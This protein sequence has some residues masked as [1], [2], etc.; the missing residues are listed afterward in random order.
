M[1]KT[2]KGEEERKQKLPKYCLQQRMSVANQG[3]EDRISP[4]ESEQRGE[5]V[6]RG[7]RRQEGKK[8]RSLGV[9]K[10]KKKG[11]KKKKK[12]TNIQNQSWVDS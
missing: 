11:R 7:N 1:K 3:K 10:K 2:K 6:R 4:I 9:G 5:N 12:K 8:R